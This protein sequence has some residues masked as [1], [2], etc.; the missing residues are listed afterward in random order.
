MLLELIVDLISQK[1]IIFSINLTYMIETFVLFCYVS[2]KFLLSIT[3]T[4]TNFLIRGIVLSFLFI[5]LC[6]VVIY[7]WIV[8]EN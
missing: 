3:W 6:I 5:D 8:L 7:G 2:F 4:T 1:I